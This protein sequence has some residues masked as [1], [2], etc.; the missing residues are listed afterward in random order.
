[1]PGPREWWSLSGIDYAVHNYVS[2]A[3]VC[4]SLPNGSSNLKLIMIK[5]IIQ[6]HHLHFTFIFFL[7]FSRK[8]VMNENNFIMHEH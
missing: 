5:I 8:T 2:S 7:I 1:M 4:L 3:S 6:L